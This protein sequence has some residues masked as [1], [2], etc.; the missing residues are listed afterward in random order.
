MQRIKRDFY[1]KKRNF[2]IVLIQKIFFNAFLYND[3]KQKYFL[4]ILVYKFN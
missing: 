1:K 2:F 4:K 3:N